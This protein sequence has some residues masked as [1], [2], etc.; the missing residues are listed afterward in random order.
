M[1][2]CLSISILHINII[3]V[4]W[5]LELDLKKNCDFQPSVGLWSEY[6]FNCSLD[7]VHVGY[8]SQGDQK[9]I[10]SCEKSTGFG[11]MT[12]TPPP[13][14]ESSINYVKSSIPDVVI[15]DMLMLNLFNVQKYAFLPFFR[16]AQVQWT[17][18]GGC[19]YE[20]A[21]FPVYLWTH[22]EFPG[23]VN[24]H[25]TLGSRSDLYTEE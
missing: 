2:I 16:H 21:V 18:T 12:L 19:H 15:V 25:C 11:Q 9:V 13:P 4:A 6:I 17:L 22:M 3:L 10:L 7:W 1:T 14:W 20:P 23:I 8:L 24:S 5:C